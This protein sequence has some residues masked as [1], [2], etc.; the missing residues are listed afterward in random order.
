MEKNSLKIFT[1]KMNQEEERVSELCDL[2]HL[3]PYK[4]FESENCSHGKR[5]RFSL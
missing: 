5:G 3:R 4:K 1:N 2:E